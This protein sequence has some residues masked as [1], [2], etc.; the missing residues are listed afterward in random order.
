MEF[1]HS[2]EFGYMRESG[3]PKLGAIIDSVAFNIFIGVIIILNMIFIGLEADLSENHI[4][5]DVPCNPMEM[6]KVRS[7]VYPPFHL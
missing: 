1:F 7:F 4:L 2:L 6:I 5:V 3:L